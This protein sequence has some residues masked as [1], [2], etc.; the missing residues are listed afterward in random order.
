MSSGSY[1]RRGSQTSH[2]N[3]SRIELLRDEIS[4]LKE[5][6][7]RELKEREGDIHNLR[8]EKAGYEEKQ[9]EME[10]EMNDHVERQHQRELEQKKEAERAS[11]KP[12][13]RMSGLLQRRPSLNS[14]SSWGSMAKLQHHVDSSSDDEKGSIAVS[15]QGSSSASLAALD[16]LNKSLNG[17]SECKDGQIDENSMQHAAD[18]AGDEPPRSIEVSPARAS[19]HD[20][21]VNLGGGMQREHMRRRPS[22]SSLMGWGKEGQE[23]ECEIAVGGAEDNQSFGRTP[24]SRRNSFGSLSAMSAGISTDFSEDISSSD[25]EDESAGQTGTSGDKTSSLSRRGGM[26]KASSMRS[27]ASDLDMESMRS[28]LQRRSSDRVV[29]ASRVATPRRSGRRHSIED[30]PSSSLRRSGGLGRVRSASALSALENMLGRDNDGDDC[31]SIGAHSAGPLLA[32]TERLDGGEGGDE[33]R[34]GR[35]KMKRRGSFGGLGGALATLGIGGG[36]DDRPEEGHPPGAMG[37]HQRRPSLGSM[38][39]FGHAKASWSKEQA[40]LLVKEGGGGMKRSSSFSALS[41]MEGHDSDSD[42]GDRS[43]GAHS[44][45]PLGMLGGELRDRGQM[46]RRPSL[47][48][49]FG[50]GNWSKEQADKMIDESTKEKMKREREERMKREKEERQKR[51]DEQMNALKSS[52]EAADKRKEELQQANKEQAEQIALLRL[53]VRAARAKREGKQSTKRRESIG[54]VVADTVEVDPEEQQRDLKNLR[55]T[56]HRGKASWTT[57]SEKLDEAD[58]NVDSLERILRRMKRKASEALRQKPL[59]DEP[60]A[61]DTSA[62]DEVSIEI[63]WNTVPDLQAIAAPVWNRVVRESDTERTRAKARHRIIATC[64]YRLAKDLNKRFAGDTSSKN[65]GKREEE[66]KENGVAKNSFATAVTCSSQTIRA[67]AN[68]LEED[69]SR[70][71]LALASAQ[72]ARSIAEKIILRD[73]SLFH[74]AKTILILFQSVALSSE[75]GDASDRNLLNYTSYRC[76]KSGLAISSKLQERLEVLRCRG[77]DQDLTLRSLERKKE[78]I[79]A[80][81]NALKQSIRETTIDIIERK[82][83]FMLGI[84]HVSNMSKPLQETLLLQ[85][86]QIKSLT[87]DV[88]ACDEKIL[89]LK[90]EI[91]KLKG[92]TSS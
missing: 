55:D 74:I 69:T 32:F 64:S 33:R 73:N 78:Q 19:L 86:D 82:Q 46:K 52:M 68:S 58:A 71:K 60:P 41:K 14:L 70:T 62:S 79:E 72:T 48:A 8:A 57:I 80:K 25:D 23:I 21:L 24:M 15:S 85:Q 20:S 29:T 76:D 49:L 37:K 40:D 75:N 88:N 12:G 39:L 67:S 6:A 54:V 35:G 77:D 18:G 81:A 10:T 65:D 87:H 47:G 22:L 44:I 7:E 92:K 5:A 11:P 51:Y 2:N 56:I 13:R 9:R 3:S 43:V 53:Q 36:D 61:V 83:Y 66:E 63:N 26:H 50:Q 90:R 45:G 42:V 38:T 59:V 16:V 91:Q 30:I 1:N 27:V 4:Q 31:N 84:R 17:G 89:G 28:K 34:Q